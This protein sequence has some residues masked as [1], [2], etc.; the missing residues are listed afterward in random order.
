MLNFKEKLSLIKAFA[1]DVDGVFTD[2]NLILL[3]SGEQVRTMN[4]RDGYAVQLAVQ[5]GYQ[6]AVISGGC[7]ETVK[8]RFVRMGIQNI[9]MPTT[10][11]NTAFG[12]FIKEHDLNPEHVLYM[13]DD[14]PDYQA[15]QQAGVKTCPADADS[16][17]KNIADY[18]SIY[19][20]GKGCVRDVIEQTLRA[21]NKWTIKSS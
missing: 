14:I 20:G 10:N 16:E 12:E 15:I 17:I 7:E 18:I 5:L 8:M 19:G 21:Q 11:K 1:F 4:V 13:G 9:F 6:I 3:P 2:G